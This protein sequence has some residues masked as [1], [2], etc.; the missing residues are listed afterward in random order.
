[1]T[2]TAVYFRDA[3]GRFVCE[4]VRTV[5]RPANPWTPAQVITTTGKRFPLA[6]ADIVLVY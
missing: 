5:T 4:D 2:P 1:M 3:S 6:S